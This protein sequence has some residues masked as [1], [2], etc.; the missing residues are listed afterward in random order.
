LK[1]TIIFHHIPKTAGTT[2]NTILTR[3]YEGKRIF[4]IDSTDPAMSIDRFDNFSI[5]KQNSFDLVR[6]HLADKIESKLSGDLKKRKILFLRNPLEHTISTFYYIKRAS[7]NRQNKIVKNFESIDDFI[8]FRKSIN[9]D[10][11]QLRHLTGDT[12]FVLKDTRPTTLTDESL[13]HKGK[14]LLDSTEFVLL[15]E[16]FDEAIL[17][18][19][20]ALNWK[21]RPYYNVQNKTK[22]RPILEDLSDDQLKLLR[23]FCYYDI[24]LYEHA[25]KIFKKKLKSLDHSHI[26]KFQF[27]NKLFRTFRFL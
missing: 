11:F 9:L 25:T 19:E 15:A 22:Q 1:E 16:Y 23:S 14:D 10:N 21:R 26:R 8:Y 17:I 6:G 13:L 7:W 20:K 2:F 27:I 12:D 5:N 18:L 4:F 24:Q 3:I